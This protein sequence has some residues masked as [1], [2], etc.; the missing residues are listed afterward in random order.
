[1]RK[2]LLVLVA[3]VAA[4]FGLSGCGGGSDPGSG[5]TGHPKTVHVSI[6]GGSITPSGDRIKVGVGQPVILKIKADHA[7][8]IHVHSTPEQHL[9]FGK[10]STTRKVTIDKPGI[11]D[12]EDHAA[13]VVIV[14]LEVS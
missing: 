5:S 7:G 4:T 10:G 2:T 3:L 6:T 11:V 8:E 9:E 1:V 14:S 13:D 12:I